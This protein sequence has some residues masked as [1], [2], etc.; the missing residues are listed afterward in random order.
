[1]KQK[2]LFLAVLCSIGI[3]VNAQTNVFPADGNVGIGTTNPQAKLDIDNNILL[4]LNNPAWGIRIKANFP[5]YNGGWSRGFFV[6]N[7][8]NIS[9]FIGL[10]ALGGC[11]NGVATMERAWI[12][13]DYD[14]SYMNFL[15]NGNVGIGTTSP[16]SILDI[17]GETKIM[18]SGADGITTTAIT[19]GN[20]NYPATQ[21]NRIQNSTSASAVNNILKFETSNGSIGCW[22]T[23]QLVL[24]G[25]GNIGIGT[26]SPDQRLTVK[27]KIHAE[28]VIVDLNVPAADYVF[29]KDYSLMPL[30]KVEQ[31]V[32]QNSHLPDIPSAAEIKEQGLSMGEMQN[33]LLKKVEEQ[34]LYI[35]A[36]NKQMEKMEQRIKELEKK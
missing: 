12:G 33:K 26:T 8:N 7:E 25:N 9:N 24:T 21:N 28:E 31:Y 22:N 1:M 11:S 18:T 19:L 17:R 23:N 34:T 29:A 10:G 30:H 36:L 16:L 15:P 4:G 27:G 13:K 32:Q 6:V 5:S 35:I 3:T 2:L 14:N 20:N